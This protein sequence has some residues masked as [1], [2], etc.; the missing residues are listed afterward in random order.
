M[1]VS[2]HNT[3]GQSHR[4]WNHP[5]KAQIPTPEKGVLGKLNHSLKKGKERGEKKKQA[6]GYLKQDFIRNMC[7]YK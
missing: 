6:Q 4:G 2:S 3:E 1:L 7:I 5:P